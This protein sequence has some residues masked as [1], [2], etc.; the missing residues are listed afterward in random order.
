DHALP[1]SME[2]SLV[3]GG[4]WQD[5]DR[6][7]DLREADQDGALDSREWDQFVNSP[8]T[9][10]GAFGELEPADLSRIDEERRDLYALVEGDHGALSWEAGVRWENTRLRITD[11]IAEAGGEQDYDHFLPS[12]SLRYDI[13]IGRFT[14]S[15]ARTVRRPQFDFLTPAT[16]DEEIGDNDFR[17]NPLLLPEK[18]WG[19]DLGY[20]HH[21]GRT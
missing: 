16:L 18:A 17:G 11:F 8:T 6:R 2:V 12:A 10:V 14:A 3:V 15:A 13:G 5:K 21:L 7:S 1:I 9:L 19:G 4:F 20:E